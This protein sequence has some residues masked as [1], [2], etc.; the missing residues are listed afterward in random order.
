MG[1]LYLAAYI[2]NQHP[3]IEWKLSDGQIDGEDRCL[4]DFRTFKPDLV[5]VSFATIH[6]AGAYSLIN[7]LKSERPGIPVV[8]GGAHPS[9]MPEEV[10]SRCKAD[11]VV[12]GEGEQAFNEIVENMLDGKPDLEQKRIISTSYIKDIDAIP[13]PARDLVDMRK[14]HGSLYRKAKPEDQVLISRGCPYNCT[15]CSNRVFKIQKPWCRLRSPEKVVDEIE[16]LQENYGIKEF[17]DQSDEFNASL[18]QA[19]GICDEMIKRNIRIPWKTRMTARGTNFSEELIEKMAETGCWV[20]SMGIESG[21]QETLNR[22]GKATTLE[23]IESNCRTIKKYGIKAGGTFML[24]N[25]WEEDGELRFEGVEESM[26]TIGFARCLR[27]KGLLD[28]V[29]F[30][31]TAPFPASPLWDTCMKFDLIPDNYL[32]S[33]ELWDAS[34]KRLMELPGISER[35]CVK[36]RREA[37]RIQT[38]ALLANAKYLNLKEL[39]QVWKHA[40]GLLKLLVKP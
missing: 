12:V 33:W 21:N 15:F 3:E 25:A 9:A 31:I 11:A 17:I 16:W 27:E 10:L 20:L 5:G 14:Y 32:G 36:L 4:D 26:N 28:R 38:S 23:G 8:C 34:W 35:D 19:I 6:A 1:I 24:F 7:K 2:R 39:S 29:S 18:K 37:G 13:F 30:T 40:K 22:I